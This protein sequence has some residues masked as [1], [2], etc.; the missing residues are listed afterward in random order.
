MLNPKV[1]HLFDKTAKNSEIHVYTDA[2][3]RAYGIVLLQRIV[4]E[5]GNFQYKLI[6]L[7]SRIIHKTHRL[8]DILR[9]EFQSLVLAMDY[10]HDIFINPDVKKVFWVDSKCL[11]LLAKNEGRSPRIH[12]FLNA[13]KTSYRPLE[14]R[15]IESSKQIADSLTRLVEHSEKHREEKTLKIMSH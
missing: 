3:D 12:K 4:D 15:W 2:S 8:V 13:A 10:F 9:K 1:L 6:D 11:F 14:F 5:E 7:V